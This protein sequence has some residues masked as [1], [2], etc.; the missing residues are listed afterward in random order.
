MGGMNEWKVG[1]EVVISRNANP[2]GQRKIA[3]V[4]KTGNVTLEGDETRQQFRPSG[5]AAK[6]ASAPS[7]LRIQRPTEELLEEL[8]RLKVRKR[9]RQ[10]AEQLADALHGGMVNATQ[11]R[12]LSPEMIGRMEKQAEQLRTLLLEL[13]QEVPRG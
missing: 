2:I 10:V 8:K 4:Y 5:Y 1:E 3:R 13:S 12:T 9:L 11:L 6:S 7:S